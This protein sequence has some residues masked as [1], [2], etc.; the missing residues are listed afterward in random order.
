M[1][2]RCMAAEPCKRPDFAEILTKLQ[3]LSSQPEDIT[4]ALKTCSLSTAAPP[5][6]LQ[7]AGAQH[8]ICAA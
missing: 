3:L 2:Y 8:S 5:D 6:R 4:G 7:E 1:I